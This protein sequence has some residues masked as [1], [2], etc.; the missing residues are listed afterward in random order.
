MLG[1]SWT[2]FSK[3]KSRCY[4]IIVYLLVF[5]VWY[6]LNQ[7]IPGCL[8]LSGNVLFSLNAQPTTCR[9]LSRPQELVEIITRPLSAVLTAKLAQ[10]NSHLHEKA[11]AK[12]FPDVHV[13]VFGCEVCARSLQVEPEK[14]LF[15]DLS[16]KTKRGGDT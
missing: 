8:S 6:N 13:I 11:R 15:V 14:S 5:F 4:S 2:T 12:G 1:W 16:F 7:S 3:I 10:L 9:L